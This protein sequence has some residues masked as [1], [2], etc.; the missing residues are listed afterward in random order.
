[1]SDTFAICREKNGVGVLTCH[2]LF[3]SHF[4]NL[5]LGNVTSQNKHV[6]TYSVSGKP[7]LRN[8][9]TGYLRRILE[10]QSEDDEIG[11]H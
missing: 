6:D 5:Y 3:F 1:M 8:R 10:R 7:V 11:W 4:C 2:W 9:Q